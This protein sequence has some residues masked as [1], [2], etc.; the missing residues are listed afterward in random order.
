MR[1]AVERGIGKSPIPGFGP[2]RMLELMFNIEQPHHDG[3]ANGGYRQMHKQEW[4][5]TDPPRQPSDDERNYT[6]GSHSADPRHPA[7]THQAEWKPVSQQ[8]KITRTN[9]EHNN[10]MTVQAVTEPA[11]V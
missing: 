1:T 6:I 10:R 7:I 2:D 9:P 5:N 11:P 8:K 3:S 4:S